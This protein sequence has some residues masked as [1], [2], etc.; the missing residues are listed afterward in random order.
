MTLV[1][2]FIENHYPSSFWF[3]FVAISYRFH[4]TAHHVYK[5]TLVIFKSVFLAILF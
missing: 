2:F 4:K 3:G 1:K 5:L